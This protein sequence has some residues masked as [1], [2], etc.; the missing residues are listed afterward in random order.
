MQ[1]RALPVDLITVAEMTNLKR[2]AKKK[3]E[4]PKPV[5]KPAP[6]PEPEKPKPTPKPEP[7]ARV[8]P[9]PPL[10]EPEVKPELIPDKTAEKKPE[11]KKKEPP[12]PES[13]KPAVEKKPQKKKPAFDPTKIA[14]LLDKIPDR[15]AQVDEAKPTE[16]KSDTPETDDPDMPLSLSEEDALRQK[17]YRCWS[18]PSFAGSPDAD[19]LFAKISFRLNQDGSIDG[20]PEIE[21]VAGGAYAQNFAEG[22]VR[23]IRQCKPYDFLPADKYGSWRD[24]TLN[25][26]LREMM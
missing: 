16:E 22:A 20:Q 11:E 23:A 4:E 2:Q 26:S 1:T 8:E 13:K 12:K 6:K 5:E 10:P 19:K 18:V 14:A 7:E 15:S 24:V 17:I 21:E 9:T 3:A 25:F